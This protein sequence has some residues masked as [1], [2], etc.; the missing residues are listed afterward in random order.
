MEK[1]DLAKQFASRLKEAMIKAGHYSE[2]SISGVSLH[3]L[4]D[5]TGYSKQICRKYLRGEA[6]PEPA[7]L[8]GIARELSV[9]AGWLLF[10]EPQYEEGNTEEIIKINKKSLYFILTK[11]VHLYRFTE[12][13]NE[14]PNYIMELIEDICQLNANE[15][16]T[17]KI[18]DMALSSV[19][20]F[21]PDVKAE[22]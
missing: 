20:Y 6:I 9:T 19:K 7:K 13:K 16:Q 11:M 14:V 4:C 12:F 21:H 1:N 17:E 8:M 3:K 10:G 5:I 15:A 22:V 2:R 18:I